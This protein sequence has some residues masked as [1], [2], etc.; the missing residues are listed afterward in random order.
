MPDNVALWALTLLAAIVLAALLWWLGSSFSSPETAA[1]ARG[2]PPRGVRAA[3]GEPLGTQPPAAQPGPAAGAAAGHDDGVGGSS[4]AGVPQ[5]YPPGT[6]RS[7]PRLTPGWGV[8]SMSLLLHQQGQGSPTAYHPALYSTSAGGLGQAG[9]L[10]V[11]PVT[12]GHAG[13]KGAEPMLESPT[14]TAA[15]GSTWP[16]TLR[17]M[18]TSS[19]YGSSI[20]GLPT[21]SSNI[22]F[23]EPSYA[24]ASK[25]G[26]APEAGPAAASAAS[27]GMEAGAST[28][29]A[30]STSLTFQ[31]PLASVP[32]W[33]EPGREHAR[34]LTMLPPPPPSP[35]RTPAHAASAP[36]Q[37]LHGEPQEQP[38]ALIRDSNGRS[39]S[40]GGSGT[41]SSSGDRNRSLQEMSAAAAAAVAAAGRSEPLPRLT[42]ERPTSSSQPASTGPPSSR[43]SPRAS[44]DLVDLLHAIQRGPR[45]GTAGAR[46][47]LTR[48]LLYAASLLPA[49]RAT[50]DVPCMLACMHRMGCCACMCDSRHFR[51]MHHHAK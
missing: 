45:M 13:A 50:G 47:D 32:E 29:A 23:A 31:S 27:A 20:E 38:R 39:S 34:G 16:P 33:P 49:L 48:C 1:G 3:E 10:G 40:S 43:G 17:T 26:A 7:G 5:P 9:A 22:P 24:A 2:G 41:S 18:R 19:S 51:S 37:Q 42:E 36:Q 21:I 14:V 44:I 11:P 46:S 25:G 8:P 28:G 12:A 6:A 35:M 4:A 15:P 30:S